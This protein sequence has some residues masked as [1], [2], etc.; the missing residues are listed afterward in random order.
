VTHAAPAPG[1]QSR[2]VLAVGIGGY[3]IW[4]LIPAWF[5]LAGRLGAGSW[6]IVGQRALWSAPWAGLLV[7]IAGHGDQVRR[8]FASPKLLGQLAVS[9]LMLVSGWSVYVWA[10]NNGHNFESSLGYF[11][12]PLLN[13]T[14]GAWLFRERLDATG[15][16]AIALAVIGVLLQTLA[17]GHLP[18]IAIFLAVTFTI[19]GVI[20]KRVEVDAQAGLFV[21]S[22]LMLPAGLALVLWLGHAGTAKF[23][24]SGPITLVLACMGPAT[25]LPLALFA[26]TARRMPLSSVAF[27]QF[28]GPTIG[29][30]IG[31]AMGE[32]L[33]LTG[34]LSFGFIWASVAVFLIGA[35]RRSRRLAGVAAAPAP[36]SERLQ[37]SDA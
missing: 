30:L 14:V 32:R 3:I 15:V 4:G 9:A 36:R 7:V 19:Y 23:G 11:I 13:M 10:V 25:V 33:S 17:L 2:R 28:T 20:R 1:G 5:I 22:M 21:E 29:F 27:L 6:E 37:A 18:L 35:W 8:V 26:W 16:A 24:A 31:L 12:N 34:V